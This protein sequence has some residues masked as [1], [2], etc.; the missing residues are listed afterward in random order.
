MYLVN[1]E[2]KVKKGNSWEKVEEGSNT[3]SSLGDCVSFLSNKY[4]RSFSNIFQGEESEIENPNEKD[5][6]FF[7][8]ISNA[9]NSFAGVFALDN[10]NFLEKIIK[11]DLK[12]FKK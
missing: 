7:W 12:E 4:S 2:T 11:I 3:Y 1:Y 9:E 5:I 10:L 6:F 8:A